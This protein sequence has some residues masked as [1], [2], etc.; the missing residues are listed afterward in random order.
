[1]ARALVAL[2]KPEDA[3]AAASHA[4]ELKPR[5]PSFLILAGEVQLDAGRAD[6]ASDLFDRALKISPQNDLARAYLR[7]ANWRQT[8]DLQWAEQLRTESL[9]DSTAFMVRLVMTVEEKLR[10]APLPMPMPVAI[11]SALPF[12]ARRFHLPIPFGDSA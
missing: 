2:D 5:D 9:P 4:I 6:A 8:G 10:P 1:M 12:C 3:V 7:L 11:P